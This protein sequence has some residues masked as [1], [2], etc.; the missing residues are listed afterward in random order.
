MRKNAQE[1][2]YKAY[3]MIHP[4]NCLV[5]AQHYSL[6][7]HLLNISFWVCLVLELSCGLLLHN[8]FYHHQLHSSIYTYLSQMFLSFP[9]PTFPSIL[10]ASQFPSRCS[11]IG[12]DFWSE[13]SIRLLQ[14]YQWVRTISQME[15]TLTH[16]CR[17]RARPCARLYRSRV[18]LW[19]G[20]K[21]RAAS[22]SRRA[23][24]Q[25]PIDSWNAAR[26]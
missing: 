11:F 17:W 14:G 12:I 4:F 26:R 24:A 7:Q 2:E 16:I 18:S 8:L 21:Q 10:K 20:S 22:Q 6:T 23:E 15:N 3:N 1:I 13:F 25:S 9:P 5:S 19:L